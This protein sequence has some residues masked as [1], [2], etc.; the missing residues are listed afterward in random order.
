MISYYST[1][2]FLK[3]YKILILGSEVT[4][5]V[6]HIVRTVTLIN[7]LIYHITFFQCLKKIM[8]EV[9]ATILHRSVFI[10]EEKLVCEIKFTNKSQ[11]DHASAVKQ[12]SHQRHSSDTRVIAPGS[13]N[14]SISMNAKINNDQSMSIAY[15]S[16]QIYCQCNL[17]Q[18]K[19][20]VPPNFASNKFDQSSKHTSFSSDQGM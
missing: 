9:K 7:Q 3:H 14:K 17:N 20:W 5:W 19:F 13:W 4:F 16:A 6:G 2:A 11:K 15:A 18:R 1:V 10:P 12:L 8:M